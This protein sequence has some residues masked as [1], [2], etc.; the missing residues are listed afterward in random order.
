M[1]DLELIDEIL[2][3]RPKLKGDQL[4]I[5]LFLLKHPG[6]SVSELER[7]TGISKS[8]VSENCSALYVK[9]ILKRYE[10]SIGK[11]RRVKYFINQGYKAK[12]I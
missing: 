4:R 7:G 11:L 3:T 5:I 12:A 1:M 8:H 6:A 2:Q 10:H 9:G